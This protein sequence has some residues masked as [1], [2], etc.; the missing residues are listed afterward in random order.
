MKES[1][2]KERMKYKKIQT[3]SECPRMRLRRRTAPRESWRGSAFFILF[4]FLFHAFKNP[5]MIGQYVARVTP[6]AITTHSQS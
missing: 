3:R 4:M 5:H 2:K 6:M 1:V